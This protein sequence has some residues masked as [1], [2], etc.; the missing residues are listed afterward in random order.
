[1]K[2][3][4]FLALVAVAGCSS[5][6]VATNLTFGPDGVEANPTLSGRVGGATVT[7]DP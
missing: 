2:F 1:M 4:V 5:P 7:I 6:L 3:L